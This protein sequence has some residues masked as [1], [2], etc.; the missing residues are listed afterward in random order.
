MTMNPF[1]RCAILLSAWGASLSALAQTTPF[2]FTEKPGPYAVGL[3]VVEQ[4]DKSR[5]YRALTD[6]LGKPTRGE[7]ARPLQ[8]LVWYPAMANAAKA[9]TVGDYVKLVAT[10]TSF[11][12]PDAVDVKA[13]YKDLGRAVDDVLWA[14]RDASP[15]TGKFPV[16]VYAPSFSSTSWE[17]ADLCEL[18]ASHGY[19]VIASPDMGAMARGMTDDVAGINA[20][21]NDIEFL[22][23]YAA[24]LPNTDMTEI[25]V[26]G[27]SWGGISNL[28][29]AAR[30]NRIKALVDLDGSVRYFPGL[31]ERAGDVHPDQMTVPLLYFAQGETTREDMAK[32]IANPANTGPSALN[33]WTHGDLLLVEMLGFTHPEF[34]SMYQRQPVWSHFERSQKA[35]YGREDG[36]AGYAWVARYTVKFLDAYLKQDAGA[37][38]FLQNTPAANGVPPHFMAANFRRAKGVAPSMDGFRGELGRQGFDHAAAVYASLQKDQTDFKLAEDPLID[39]GSDL[40]SHDHVAE[41]I[42]IFKLTAQEYPRSSNAFERLGEAYARARQKSL[43]IAA[44]EMALDIDPRNDVASE[45]L[46]TLK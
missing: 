33:A 43:A 9:M 10:E 4:Y 1:Y 18:L 17:N 12:K 32:Q 31:V 29:A 5:A 20:Q 13:N 3:K 22:I 40:M 14:V 15:S 34:S 28:F 38:T 26:A 45:Q 19:V 46:K 25:A 42:N 35:D 30:D 2:R 27:W 24:G 16:V 39:W 44:F 6:S 37:L 11:G 41:S 8:T 23:G 21:A 7:R 36:M